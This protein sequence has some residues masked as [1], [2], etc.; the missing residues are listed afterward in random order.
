MAGIQVLPRSYNPWTQALPGFLQQMVFTKMSQK[1]Q[2]SQTEERRKFAAEELKEQRKNSEKIRK[3]KQDFILKTQFQETPHEHV[4]AGAD[5]VEHN[6]KYYLPRKK[7]P[8][9]TS[10]MR[11]YEYAVLKGFK[12]TPEDWKKSGGVNVNIGT[13]TALHE[14]KQNIN[15]LN[16][17]KRPDFGMTVVRD[18]K[19]A[20]G[21]NWD[22]MEPYKKAELQFREMDSQVKAAYRDKT[23]IFDD[24]RNPPGW[25]VGNKLVVRY[26]DIL[27]QRRDKKH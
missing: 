19:S 26:S 6:G 1:F 9:D 3:E 18:L 13:K 27:K 16:K 10:F 8:K 23:V 7:V 22:I 2:K 24:D 4:P 20:H 5:F 21:D 17:V 15:A 12:G 11:N 25:Y 14:A